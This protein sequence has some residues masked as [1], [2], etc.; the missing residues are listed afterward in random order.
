[1]LM[2]VLALN[3]GGLAFDFANASFASFVLFSSGLVRSVD[4]L[5][6]LDSVQTNSL[7]HLQALY[8]L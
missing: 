7:L 8:C 2:L 3:F 5:I 4:G 6:E 1:M